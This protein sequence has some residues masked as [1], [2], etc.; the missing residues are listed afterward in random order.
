MYNITKNVITKGQFELSDILKKID[1]FWVKGSLNDEERDEL[2][3]LAQTKANPENSIDMMTKL[4]EL[5]KRVKELEI[6]LATK[7]EVPEDNTSDATETVEY[8]EFEV[9]KWYYAGDKIKFDGDNYECIAPEGTVCVW[10][11]K[12]YPPYWKKIDN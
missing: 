8:E 3:E 2:I 6:L 5:D 11:P 1:N 10:S 12:D 4:E 7:E 9:G